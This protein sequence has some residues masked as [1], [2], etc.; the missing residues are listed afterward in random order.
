MSLALR[1][2]TKR[3]VAARSLLCR[4][5]LMFIHNQTRE[6][7]VHLANTFYHEIHFHLSDDIK[8]LSKITALQ[9]LPA[10]RQDLYQRAQILTTQFSSSL[11]SINHDSTNE[12]AESLSS[13]ERDVSDR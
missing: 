12:L 10:G 6:E 3:Y 11:K 2:E 13:G 7:S 8:A 4:R 5:A 1:R 9:K